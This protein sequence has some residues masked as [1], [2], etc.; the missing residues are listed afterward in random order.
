MAEL[1]KAQGGNSGSVVADFMEAE[2]MTESEA[3]TV[4][5]GPAESEGKAVEA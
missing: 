1:Q 5:T 4:E 3:T 2:V